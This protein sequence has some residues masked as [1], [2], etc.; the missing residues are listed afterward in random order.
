MYKQI[1][2]KLKD[3]KIAILGFGKEG[4]S[5]YNFIRRYLNKKK[6]TIIDKVKQ[7]INDEYVDIISGENYLEGLYKYDLIIKSPGITLK[8]IDI[9]NFKDRITSQLELV[10]EVYRKNIIGITGTKGKSTTTSLIY[11]IIKDQRDKV[12]ILGN[13]GNPLLDRVEEYDENSIL[14]IEM[15]SDQL[16]FVDKSPHIAIILNLFED[17]LDHAG[18]IEH[19]HD[20]KMNIFKY[21]D[22]NDYCIY[23]DDNYY[24]RQRMESSQYKGI[25]Y[26]IRFDYEN[27]NQNSVRIKDKEVYLNNELLYTDDER[28]LIG[29]HNLKNIM[30]ALTV[31]KIM[32]LN[33]DKANKII[34]EFKGLKYRMECI[35]T[36]DD[37]TYY[38]DTIATVPSAT[39]SAITAIKNVDTLIF[40]GMDRKIDYTELIDYLKNSDISNLVCMPTTGTK[41][42]KI[43]ELETNKNIFYTD[44]L[45]E[46]YDIAKEKTKKGYSCLLSPAASSYEYF[47]NF[48]EK[49]KYFENIVKKINFSNK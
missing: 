12:F 14:V 21:Q 9:S 17:H 13:I 33:L 23:S 39:I 19:Y 26:N 49:G 18:T 37:I 31:A 1:I 16:E 10:L 41:I 38:N 7:E 43:L 30:F 15:S 45:E 8:D 24:L 34:K 32:N 20:S 22:E 35:G 42:G 3:K 28:K 36:Y 40:G 11:E 44:S 4:K 47:K 46:A 27:L 5:T 29:D 25:K 48:E 2:N 6:L